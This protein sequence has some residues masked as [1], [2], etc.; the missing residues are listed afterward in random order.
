M[1]EELQKQHEA[2]AVWAG[3]YDDV[4][5]LWLEVLS[6]TGELQDTPLPQ[7]WCAA[8]G[9]LLARYQVLESEHT[10]CR[11]HKQPK[12]NSAVLLTAVAQAVSRNGVLAAGNRRQ[13]A[14]RV[15]EMLQKRGRPGG[16]DMRAL[17]QAQAACIRAPLHPHLAAVLVDRI[18][19]LQLSPEQGVS[20]SHL[21][22]ICAPVTADEAA[23]AAARA[24]WTVVENC[25]IPDALR[26]RVQSAL[27][28][29]L[30]NLVRCGVVPSGE[31]LAGLTPPL[32]AA[33][34]CLLYTSPSPRD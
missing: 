11:K 6:E 9:V 14:H 21:E 5:S 25:P 33:C 17:R 32:A 27:S 30:L 20:Q 2:V 31:V 8:G 7:A 19:S 34:T 18:S 4:L 10:F 16:A 23:A 3:Y 22:A 24:H 12:R 26:R 15:A 13:V 1:R 29:P 28:A